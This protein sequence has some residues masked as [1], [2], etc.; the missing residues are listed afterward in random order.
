MMPAEESITAPPGRETD[1]GKPA[2]PLARSLSR[3]GQWSAGRASQDIA[4][5]VAPLGGAGVF[6]LA[7]GG[8]ERNPCPVPVAI[9]P[10]F[11]CSLI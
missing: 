2:C 4:G 1:S 11:S 3:G 9:S 5:A 10:G 8:I 7:E 6:V